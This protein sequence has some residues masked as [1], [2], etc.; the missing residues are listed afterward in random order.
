MKSP[1]RNVHNLM[2]LLRGRLPG[3]LVIQYSNRCNAD[4]PQCGM[5]RSERISRYTLGKDNARRLIDSAAAKGVR[6]LSLT[7]GE[8]LMFLDDIVELLDHASRAG[9]PYVRTGTNG[10]IFRDSDRPG[11]HDNITRIVEKLASTPLY[12][13]W[14][15]LDSANPA[16]HEQMRGLTGVVK[17]IE[18]ALPI[19]HEHGIYPAVN[20]GI[21]RATGSITEQPFLAKMD[22]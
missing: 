14:V 3:Q 2:P 13:V 10:F 1:L 20:L 19:F 6:S 9:I 21:N 5:R 15:S 17:G 4:C 18:K 22:R 12:T 8:P 16:S 7:G 11:F